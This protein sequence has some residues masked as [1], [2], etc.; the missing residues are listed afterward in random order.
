VE[1]A[2]MT[3]REMRSG[4]ARDHLTLEQESEINWGWDYLDK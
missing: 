4:K 2:E 3:K 1:A